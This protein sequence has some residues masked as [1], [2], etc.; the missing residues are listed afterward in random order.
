M[1]PLLN[2]LY[3][4]TPDA[5]LS[6]DGANVVVSADGSEIFRI[7][8]H[9]IQ[10]IL[11][12]GYHGASPG[13]MKL[14]V[15]NSVALS[16][17]SP[18]GR[19]IARI[20]GPVSGNIILRNAH[21]G[22]ISDRD[23]CLRLSSM[24]IFGKIQNSRASLRRFIRDYPDNPMVSA[25]EIAADTLKTLSRSAVNASD[26]ASLRGVEGQA[27]AVYFDVFQHLI[28]NGDK[29]FVFDKRVRRPPT[30][31]VNAML[32]FGYSL[33]ALDCASALEGVGLDPAAGFMHAIRPGRNSLAL[34][35]MEEMRAY[36][37]DRH[38]LSLI[39]NR[40]LSSSDF[41]FLS[42]P[43]QPGDAPVI[44]TDDGRK[45][46]LTAWQARKKKVITHPFLQEKVEIGLLPHIQSLLL[47]KYLRGDLDNYPVFLLR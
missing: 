23:F 40:Q 10:S 31:A 21:Y 28:L 41:K 12:F 33:L 19:F 30:D 37:V 17:F 3:V 34:D 46:F 38:V 8:I 9:N 7:P 39:N 18:S 1:K 24:F 26:I 44:L 45:K 42:S 13:V 2:T 29:T 27:A 32:S 20:Q 35:L 14:C 43:G 16:F 36:I 11:T 6:K 15:D 22:Y 5:F 47:A 4:T 25:V